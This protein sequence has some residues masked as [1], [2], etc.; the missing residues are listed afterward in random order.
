M[1]TEGSTP[2]FA[3]RRASWSYRTFRVRY[4]QDRGF[5]MYDSTWWRCTQLY[6]CAAAEHH[7][8]ANQCML[9]CQVLTGRPQGHAQTSAVSGKSTWGVVVHIDHW[10]CIMTP[11]S[12]YTSTPSI[13]AHN[14]NIPTRQG[15]TVNMMPQGKGKSGNTN[16]RSTQ[17]IF[18]HSG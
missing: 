12:P 11:L 4:V 16:R 14:I 13:S 17:V 5:I 18:I 8:H 2:R 7:H 9:T 3:L 6:R 1:T 15:P 10:Y